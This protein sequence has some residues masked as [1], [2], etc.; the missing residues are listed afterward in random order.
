MIDCL[1]VLSRCPGKFIAISR[2]KIAG[3]RLARVQG[4]GCRITSDAVGWSSF[5]ATTTFGVSH[6]GPPSPRPSLTGY[7]IQPDQPAGEIAPGIFV[8]R[9]IIAQPFAQGPEE[10]QGQADFFGL[11]PSSAAIEQSGLT[12]PII[13]RD[14]LKTIGTQWCGCDGSVRSQG[15]LPRAPPADRF[16]GPF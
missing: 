7:A 15:S 14:R 1:I 13:R 10:N 6:C 8:S 16:P 3:I 12:H 5:R 2:S 9:R 4:C 11:P